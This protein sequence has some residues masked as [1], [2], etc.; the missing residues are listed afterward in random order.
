MIKIARRALAI[1]FVTLISLFGTSI[2][3]ADQSCN[4]NGDCAFPETC[5]P[6]SW[7][8]LRDTGLQCRYGLSE[9]ISL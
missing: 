2:A 3:S 9:S 7:R 8:L 5:Q 4:F 1:G 6:T